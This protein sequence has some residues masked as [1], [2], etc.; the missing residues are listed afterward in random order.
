MSFWSIIVLYCTVLYRTVP[1]R[2]VPYRTV[3]Y[4][5]VRKKSYNNKKEQIRKI[6]LTFQFHPSIHFRS[7]QIM[8]TSHQIFYGIL[9][10]VFYNTYRTY[11]FLLNHHKTTYSTYGTYICKICNSYVRMYVSTYVL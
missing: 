6:R 11:V 3:P 7:S 9:P 1:Y 4:R 8:I 5:T 2:T 10:V